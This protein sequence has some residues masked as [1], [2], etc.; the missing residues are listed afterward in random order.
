MRLAEDY[1]TPIE[2][3]VVA[4]SESSLPH[5][6]SSAKASSANCIKIS[7]AKDSNSNATTNAT[8]YVN[9]IDTMDLALH[10]SAHSQSGTTGV[11]NLVT[12]DAST[13]LFHDEFNMNYFGYAAINANDAIS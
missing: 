8:Y 11:E 5:A 13:A 3:S 9:E 7:S 1:I 2:N 4:V 6:V 12:E 10:M